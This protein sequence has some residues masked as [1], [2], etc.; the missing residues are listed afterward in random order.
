MGI[1]L[2]TV[3]IVVGSDTLRRGSFHTQVREV[4]E[5]GKGLYPTVD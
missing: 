5:V 3:G 4:E 2:F 1:D